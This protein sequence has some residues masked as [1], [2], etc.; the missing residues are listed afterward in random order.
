MVIK[1][2]S[3]L[4]VQCSTP[5]LHLMLLRVLIWVIVMLCLAWISHM[6]CRSPT[7]KR[8]AYTVRSFHFQRNFNSSTVGRSFC[9][10]LSHQSL[11][12]TLS[13]HL[14]RSAPFH[15]RAFPPHT[16][17]SHFLSFSPSGWLLSHLCSFLNSLLK[18][19]SF[20]GII[21]IIRP[22]HCLMSPMYAVDSWY[23]NMQSPSTLLFYSKT[24]PLISTAPLTDVMWLKPR[25]D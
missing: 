1:C 25:T 13:L 12:S 16:A 15:S 10:I 18:L 17:S 24:H 5:A 4:S 9:M 7:L 14:L 11:S 8:R 2:F 3:H 20:H 23:L 22:S 6:P 19:S 21:S